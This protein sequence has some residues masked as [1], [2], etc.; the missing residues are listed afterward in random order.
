MTQNQDDLQPQKIWAPFWHKPCALQGCLVLI[1]FLQFLSFS[2]II[3]RNNLWSFHTSSFT[4]DFCS[5]RLSWIQVIFHILPGLLQSLVPFKEIQDI[6]S[7][8][9]T[10][11]SIPSLSVGAV[12]SFTKKFRF[13]RCLWLMLH[14]EQF[15]YIGIVTWENKYSETIKLYLLKY[16]IV[17]HRNTIG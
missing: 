14:Q 12:A 17:Q 2:A 13:T 3:L 7:S 1:V 8:P 6:V 10:P 11:F 16:T 4:F 15:F 9:Q 5:S